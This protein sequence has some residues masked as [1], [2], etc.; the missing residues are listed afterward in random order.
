MSKSEHLML[1]SEAADYALV[2]YP[3]DRQ[4]QISFVQG[5]LYAQSRANVGIKTHQL[6]MLFQNLL[7]ESVQ[8]EVSVESLLRDH[9]S[10]QSTQSTQGDNDAD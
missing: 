2:L 7:D 6:A 10:T 5:A 1:I 3:E 8:L 9:L 4:K